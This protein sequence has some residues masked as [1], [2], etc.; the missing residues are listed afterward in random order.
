MRKSYN[1]VTRELSEVT[2]T[3]IKAISVTAISTLVIVATAGAFAPTIATALVGSQFTGLSGAAL[4]SACLAYIGGGAVAVGGAGMAG[5]TA[6]IVGGS[7]ILGAGIGGTLGTGLGIIGI[8]GK[9]ATIRESAKLIVATREIF[10][11][12]EHDIAYSN[13]VYEQ[14]VEKIRN[15]E[16]GLVELKLKKDVAT[17][18]EKKKLKREIKNAEESINAM[19]IAR[20]SMLKYNSSFEIGMNMQNRH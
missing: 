2:K 17:N 4:T 15:V 13:T 19:K 20:K 5:G 9:K 3:T 14:Y 10:L 11:N 7:A 16:H 6:V 8:A 18:E 12:D 1:K